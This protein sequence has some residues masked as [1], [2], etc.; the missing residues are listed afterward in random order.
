MVFF[1][2]QY[3]LIKKATR[4]TARSTMNAIFMA[5][6]SEAGAPAAY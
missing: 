6:I 3:K 5:F 2:Q 1:Q 4:N